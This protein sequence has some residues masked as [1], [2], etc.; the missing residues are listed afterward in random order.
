MLKSFFRTFADNLLKMSLVGAIIVTGLAS[1]FV[2]WIFIHPI[3]AMIVAFIGIALLFTF[4]IDKHKW[5]G[6]AQGKQRR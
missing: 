5:H 6:D 3:V 1:W 4:T 2:M